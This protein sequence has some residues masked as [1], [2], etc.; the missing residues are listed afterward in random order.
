MPSFSLLFK[1]FCVM[2]IRVFDIMCYYIIFCLLFCSCSHAAEDGGSSYMESGSGYSSDWTHTNPLIPTPSPSPPPP[3]SPSPSSPSHSSQD[4]SAQESHPLLWTPNAT[5]PSS[6]RSES[7]TESPTQA[8]S[9][10]QVSP[11]RLYTCTYVYSVTFGGMHTYNII[12]LW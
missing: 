6:R 11:A 5:P 10:P 1:K 2:Y 12:V 8:L 4:D 3:R 7:T 9:T